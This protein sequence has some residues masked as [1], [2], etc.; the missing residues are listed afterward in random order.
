[1]RLEAGLLAVSL[2]FVIVRGATCA[3][4][5]K[6]SQKIIGKPVSAELVKL[7][8][9]AM[10]CQPSIAADGLLRS[11]EL[12]PGENPTWKKQVLETAFTLAGK[13]EQEY[14]TIPVP[15]GFTDTL[16]ALSATSSRRQQVDSLSLQLRAARAML[17]YDATLAR[18]MFES[19]PIPSLP[20]M[21]CKDL[22]VPDLSLY[23]EILKVI[24][25][26]TFQTSEINKGDQEAFLFRRVQ[27]ITSPLQLAPTAVL[28]LDVNV[29]LTSRE[30]LVTSLAG[31]MF[32]IKSD[33]RSF[34]IA[35]LEQQLP[36]KIRALIERCQVSGIS[37]A[38]LASAFQSFYNTHL[39]VPSCADTAKSTPLVQRQAEAVRTFNEVSYVRNNHNQL[40]TS[41]SQ[42]NRPYE[43]A[44]SATDL[45]AKSSQYR[46]LAKRLA[47]TRLELE[48]SEPNARIHLDETITAID[49]WNESDRLAPEEL[50]ALRSTLLFWAFQLANDPANCRL[51]SEAYVHFFMS[52]SQERSKDPAMWTWCVS[53]ALALAHTEG[54]WQAEILL[55]AFEKSSDP[56]LNLYAGLDRRVSTLRA[57]GAKQS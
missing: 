21:T 50:F 31:S 17:P 18:D 13:V 39:T 25:E 36:D 22:T 35:I 33:D 41:D 10:V 42:S 4:E 51:A 40:Q 57:A 56:G 49:S 54:P 43:D 11:V 9:L 16:P 44:P 15:V 34:E 12:A 28:L 20:A 48:N 29:S 52:S 37:P 46:S 2:S 19:I 45:T 26:K 8:D 5:Q 32:G 30:R 3:E 1:M 6:I 7:E 27:A 24:T 38:G 55:S 14:P 47:R 53:Q 23:Y